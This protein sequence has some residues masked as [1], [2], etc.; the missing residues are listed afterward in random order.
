MPL[1]QL[2]HISELEAM[3]FSRGMTS[4]DKESLAR[5]AVN[6]LRH[7]CPSYEAE[8]RQLAGRAF[9]E[10]AYLQLRDRVLEKIAELY[11]ELEEECWRQS[12]QAYMRVFS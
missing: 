1:E 10:L 11:P 6:Y 5:Y 8:L 12:N 9:K 7:A 4:N 3:Q 2:F